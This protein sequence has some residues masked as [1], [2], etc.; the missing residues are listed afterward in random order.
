MFF[1]TEE[2]A[3]RD[4]CVPV[5]KK[6]KTNVSVQTP[7]NVTRNPLAISMVTTKPTVQRLCVGGNQTTR[8]NQRGV[9]Q[10]SNGQAE[11]MCST[12]NSVSLFF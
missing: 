6:K 9:V 3:S 12:I 2:V 11:M 4:L 5:Y 10:V 7:T 8:E 1:W